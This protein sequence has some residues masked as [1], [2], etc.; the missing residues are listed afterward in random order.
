MTGEVGDDLLRALGAE[1]P[2]QEYSGVLLVEW[3]E[4]QLRRRVR[5]LLG[6]GGG[7]GGALPVG[8]AAGQDKPGVA[9]LSEPLQD[10]VDGIALASGRDLVEGVDHQRFG[11]A[12][13]R[14]R[15]SSVYELARC[16]PR[17]TRRLRQPLEKVGLPHPGFAKD[18]R[19]RRDGQDA[20]LGDGPDLATVTVV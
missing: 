11:V 8:D 15:V 18:D 19:R 5:I 13:Q 16:A 1:L 14:A 7:R 3:V 2:R 4:M 12:E 20:V 6:D 17:V 10:E 9:D